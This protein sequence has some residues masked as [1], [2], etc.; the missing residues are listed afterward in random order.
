M[1]LAIGLPSLLGFYPSFEP[2]NIISARQSSHCTSNLQ[3]VFLTRKIIFLNTLLFQD[4]LLDLHVTYKH[5]WHC[6]V[7]T[8]ALVCPWQKHSSCFGFCLFVCLFCFF[9]LVLVSGDRLSLM[10]KLASFTLGHSPASDSWV[11]EMLRL[12]VCTSQQSCFNSCVG[13]RQA[14]PQTPL[15]M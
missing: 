11:L 6:E 1:A 13:G 2:L 8:T 3:S 15:G 5:T 14:L 7:E 12:H 10:P 4:Y 9:L